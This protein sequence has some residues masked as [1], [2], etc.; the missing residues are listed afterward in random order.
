MVASASHAAFT[1]ALLTPFH[2]LLVVCT[3]REMRRHGFADP[4]FV[5]MILGSK[6]NGRRKPP[7]EPGVRVSAA[8]RDSAIGSCRYARN[9]CRYSSDPVIRMCLA[10]FDWP[11][12]W[13]SVF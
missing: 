13:F 9:A 12:N 5:K 4:A 8:R 6:T 1:P 10:M 7:A 2:V 11:M 3:M